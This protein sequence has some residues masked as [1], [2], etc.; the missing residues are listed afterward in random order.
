MVRPVPRA[1]LL[2]WPF[3]LTWLPLVGVATVACAAPGKREAAAL[4]AAVD[5]FRR[6]PAP[7]RAVRAHAV[8]E[9]LCTDAKVCEAKTACVAAVDPTAQA[10]AIMDE[11]QASTERVERGEL[12]PDSPEANAL[13]GKLDEAGKLLQQGKDHMAT[14]DDRLKDLAV[15][16]GS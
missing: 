8:S 4:T 1:A 15:T 9:V 13:P 6:A 12:D 14:C 10:L 2:A 11:V 16:F 7:V 5:G 3:A